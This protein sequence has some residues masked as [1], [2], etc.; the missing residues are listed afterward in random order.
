MNSKVLPKLGKYPHVSE[1]DVRV[2]HSLVF[3]LIRSFEF[4]QC[5]ENF[6]ECLLD[7]GILNFQLVDS[8][9]QVYVHHV[10]LAIAT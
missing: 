6:F 10:K 5:L 3:A 9:N 8:G 2:T 1:E 4:T 7:F